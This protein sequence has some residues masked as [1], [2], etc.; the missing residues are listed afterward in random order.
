MG[1]LGR[2]TLQSRPVSTGGI[3]GL[4]GGSKFQ[5]RA[6]LQWR[7]C[8]RTQAASGRSV[9]GLERASKANADWGL[10]HAQLPGAA[11]QPSLQRN[12]RKWCGKQGEEVSKRERFGVYE[13]EGFAKG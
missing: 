12:E 2:F 5:C 7:G 1:R 3:A 10:R 6:G 9:R 8:N 11:A 4:E 13:V